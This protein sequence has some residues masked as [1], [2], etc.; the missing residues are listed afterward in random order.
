MPE[1]VQLS[2]LFQ[3]YTRCTIRKNT[4]SILIT[5]GT[6]GIAVFSKPENIV[7]RY[8]NYE[9]IIQ[10]IEMYGAGFQKRGIQQPL[11]IIQTFGLLSLSKLK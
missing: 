2:E 10:Q 5:S 3:K 1:T 11:I 4:G 9:G 6:E 8:N 7:G